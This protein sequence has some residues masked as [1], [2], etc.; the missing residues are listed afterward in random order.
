MKI[1]D[2]I[3]IIIKSGNIKPQKKLR[4]IQRLIEEYDMAEEQ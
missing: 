2:E 3:L 4:M 1:L